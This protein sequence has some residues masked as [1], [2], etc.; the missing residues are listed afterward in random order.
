MCAKHNIKYAKEKLNPKRSISDDWEISQLIKKK[1][2][3]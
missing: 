2:D 3:I 1:L